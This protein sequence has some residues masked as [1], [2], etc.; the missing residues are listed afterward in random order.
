MDNDLPEITPQERKLTEAL[1]LL[2]QGLYGIQVEKAQT[3]LLLKELDRSNAKLTG[4][5]E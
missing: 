4:V 3:D 2:D 5:I 1:A